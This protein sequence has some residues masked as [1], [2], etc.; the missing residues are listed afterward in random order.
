MGPGFLTAELADRHERSARIGIGPPDEVAAE[1]RTR[2]ASI[3]ETSTRAIAFVLRTSAP[4]CSL[5]RLG[6]VFGAGPRR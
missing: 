5:D 2:I 1:I 4:P 6:L 3:G